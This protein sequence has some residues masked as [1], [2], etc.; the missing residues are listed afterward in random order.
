MVKYSYEFKR[1]EALL[2]KLRELSTVSEDSS[3]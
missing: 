1:E 3:N 2:K